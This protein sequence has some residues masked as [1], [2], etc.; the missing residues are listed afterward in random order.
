MA[1]NESL[2]QAMVGLNQTLADLC[3]EYKWIPEGLRF[4]TPHLSAR[5]TF[6]F[7]FDVLRRGYCQLPNPWELGDGIRDWMHA[8]V[9][10]MGQFLHRCRSWR[11][12]LEEFYSKSETFG[13]NHTTR[14]ED[15]VFGTPRIREDGRGWLTVSLTG[16]DDIAMQARGTG[17]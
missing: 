4:A 16:H 3:H 8:D 1:R 14:F 2:N 13:F 9:H 6:D 10:A 15:L 11:T 12:M 7:R 17:R 5:G